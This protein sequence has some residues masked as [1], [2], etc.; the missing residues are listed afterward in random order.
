MRGVGKA[1]GRERVRQRAHQSAKTVGTAP[2]APLP[3]LRA[4]NYVLP[5][6]ASVGFLNCRMSADALG[7]M[8]SAML[9]V[10]R[11][12]PR[13]IYKREGQAALQEVGGRD[14]A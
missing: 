6:G 2:S 4:T 12:M 5:A 14:G 9:P 7:C 1:A 8:P 10:S 11:A 3:T 13:R